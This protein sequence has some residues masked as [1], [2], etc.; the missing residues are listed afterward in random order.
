MWEAATGVCLAKM[1]GHEGKVRQN[2]LHFLYN[3]HLLY[4]LPGVGC[5]P[6]QREAGQWRQV[7]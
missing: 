2:P 6:G 5:G 3:L 4:H 7:G 1:V